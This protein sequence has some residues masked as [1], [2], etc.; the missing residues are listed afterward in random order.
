MKTAFATAVLLAALATTGAS[1][2][3]INLTGR[4]QCMALCLGPPGGF[5]FITQ[6]GWDL[7]LVN[8]VGAASRAWV[9]YPGQSGSKE[10]TSAP[11]IRPTELCCNSTTEQFGGG[12]PSCCWHRL[13]LC[14]LMDSEGHATLVRMR[15]SGLGGAMGSPQSIGLCLRLAQS[16]LATSD[17]LIEDDVLLHSWRFIARFVIQRQ[18]RLERDPSQ[19]RHGV[20]KTKRRS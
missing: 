20:S 3:A 5:G 14:E 17:E 8:D 2:Q 9:D 6:N 11:S 13:R 1:A 15:Q 7:N 10:R 4:W 19:N 16:L 18:S 12:R